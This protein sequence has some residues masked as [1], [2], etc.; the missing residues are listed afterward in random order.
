MVPMPLF[1]S[2]GGAQAFG[3]GLA[4]AELLEDGGLDQPL[5]RQVQPQGEARERLPDGRERAVAHH[6]EQPV[7]TLQVGVA[8]VGEGD[9]CVA[10]VG[11]HGW[12]LGVR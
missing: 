1:A 12:G 9:A 5:H 3:D 2:F 4:A 6:A 7:G 8:L 11:E 10:Q